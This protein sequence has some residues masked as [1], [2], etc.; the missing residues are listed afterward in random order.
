MSRRDHRRPTRALVFAA[1]LLGCTEAESRESPQGPAGPPPAAKVEVGQ[2]RD[3]GLSDRW[4]F[5]GD[6]RAT[7]RAEL[8]A[9]AEG[10]VLEVAAREGDRVE[11]G[12]V[13]LKIDGTLAQAR[14]A[15]AKASRKETLEELEQAKRDRQRAEALGVDILAEAEI[16]QD[17]TRANTLATR[18]RRLSAAEREAKAL[19]S[20][21]Q[22]MAPFTGV[23]A[24]R[25]VD[26]GDWVQPGDR[27]LDL[28]DDTTVEVIVEGSAELVRR[29]ERGAIATL[30]E[31][32]DDGE[33]GE[34]TAEIVGVVRALDPVTR[35]AKV[36]LV[37]K[38]T[39]RW[40]LPGSSVDVVFSIDRNDPGVVVPRDA[41]VYGAVDVRVIKVE[42]GKAA[43]VLVQVVATADAEALV[44]GDGLS[45]GD[46]VV[47]KGNERLRPGQALAIV[48]GE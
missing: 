5:L 24:A 6:V 41:L 46:Q 45:V 1:L 25:H 21:H 37:P 47:T 48:Q 39:A 22:I 36:R 17:V 28:V 31:P 14:V 18:S 27:I 9:G 40:L 2:A 42:D 23:V 8:G 20:R 11:V 38:D 29:I 3:G 19:L 30:R 34:V 43:P 7:R 32:T 4:T 35:T 26:P 33:A 15:A 16:E 13:L 44:R 10:E 12:A